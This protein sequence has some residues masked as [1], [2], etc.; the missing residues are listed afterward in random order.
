MNDRTQMEA[1]LKRIV[2]PELRAQGFKGTFPHF[3]RVSDRVDLLT[4]QFDRRGGGFIMEVARGETAGHITHWG[5]C[6]PAEKLRAWDLHPGQR[7]R[8]QPG[9]G[10][11]TDSWFRY[12][13]RLDCDTVAKTALEMVKNHDWNSATASSGDLGTS[14]GPRN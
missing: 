10:P 13:G 1:A 14:T 7:K 3:R 4:F 11:G 2:I 6:I 9:R 12:D 8:L 5:K